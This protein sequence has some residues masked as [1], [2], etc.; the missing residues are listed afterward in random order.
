MKIKLV[1]TIL[2]MWLSS[3]AYA[4]S[5]DTSS[6]VLVIF[7]AQV[8][9]KVWSATLQ[10][11]ND[12][13]FVLSTIGQTSE[14][15]A[16]DATFSPITNLLQ[17][18]K[19]NVDGVQYNAD[20]LFVGD[21]TFRLHT[22]SL[23]TTATNNRKVEAFVF[24][25][26]Y[27]FG[28][29][30]AV[31]P[32]Y[33]PVVLFENGTA[34]VCLEQAIED[35][36]IDKEKSERPKKVGSWRKTSSDYVIQWGGGRGEKVAKGSV[37]PPQLLLPSQSLQGTYKSIGGGGNTALGGN[38]LTASVKDLTF[39]QDGSFEQ[40]NLS[41]ASSAAGIG[42]TKRGKSGSWSLNK[43]TLILEYLDGITAR[44]T[45]FHADKPSD[46]DALDVLWI[47]GR[48]YKRRD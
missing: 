3:T 15:A 47:G 46:P 45:V 28:V 6:K 37:I 2:F 25:L 20:L 13:D 11:T 35:I 19:I 17:V 43:S 41:F 29:G 34:C 48:D 39:Y 33:D 40:S 42:W 30:G 26:T 10:R 5:Y 24:D 16:L 32:D 27:N 36:N 38:V 23:S 44:T 14:N 8:E 7:A 21:N 1:T 31:F 4:A 12:S 22:V 9:N 18:S